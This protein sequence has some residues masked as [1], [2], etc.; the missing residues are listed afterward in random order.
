MIN[1]AARLVGEGVSDP[2]DI[3]TG[4]RLGGGLPEGTCRRAD[5][6]GLDAV[7][8]KL[9]AA[10]RKGGPNATRRVEDP[11]SDSSGVTD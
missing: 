4:M 10:S 5:K 11:K 9:Q 7:L 2:E 1:A 6:I 8:K 3:D